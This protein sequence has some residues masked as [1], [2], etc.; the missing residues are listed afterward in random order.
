MRIYPPVKVDIQVFNP[1][2]QPHVGQAAQRQPQVVAQ[3]VGVDAPF[4]EPGKSLVHIGKNVAGVVSIVVLGGQRG[5]F[6]VLRWRVEGAV[7]QFAQLERAAGHRPID[8]VG[9]NKV[10]TPGFDPALPARIDLLAR[11]DGV[12][13]RQRLKDMK[14]PPV[15]P[16]PRGKRRQH[17]QSTD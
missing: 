10:E 14:G 8:L 12:A 9:G 16:C 4:G 2:A 6:L 3:G 11:I 7:G 13:G 1:R 15:A 5:G 17:Q